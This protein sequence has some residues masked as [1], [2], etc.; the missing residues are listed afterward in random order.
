[1]TGEIIRSLSN[2]DYHACQYAI[3]NSG[4]GDIL[5]SP[6]HYW[7]KHLNPARPP[8][9]VRGGQLEGSLAHCTILEPEAFDD[10]YMVG[11][12]VR[13]GTKA[14]DAAEAQAAGRVLIKPDQ[15]DVAMRQ[16]EAVRNHPELREYLAAG[17][18]EVSAF[19]EDP[20]T[21]V[22]C[23]C[24]P[25]WV[26]GPIVLDV[27]TYSDADPDEFARQVARKG[28][29]RQDAFYTDGYGIA[30]GTEVERFLFVAVESDYP[31]AVSVTELDD[32]ARMI[33][34]LEYRRGVDRYA[35]CVESGEWPGY[36]SEIIPI[37]LPAYK[38]L[39]YQDDMEIVA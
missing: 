39:Q 35:E 19:W 9:R 10:R 29:Y 30:A 38:V 23:R 33:G 14:W 7:A 13:R 28:Y 11:P 1:M 2:E 4:L 24:R 27:K 25:D 34:R 20:E 18:A 31:Y 32:E 8:E 37:G 21:G 22:L 6:M 3:S 16:A 36:G 5:R 15:Y 17:E 26:N 12:D